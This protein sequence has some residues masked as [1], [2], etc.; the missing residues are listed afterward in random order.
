MRIGQYTQRGYIKMGIRNL[1]EKVRDD[2][3]EPTKESKTFNLIEPTEAMV[4]NVLQKYSDGET[5]DNIK[6]SIKKKG[7]NNTLSF[8]QIKEIINAYKNPLVE[9]EDLIKEDL[10]EEEEDLI[11]EDLIEEEEDLI[12][13]D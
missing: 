7:S 8:S 4:R 1:V 12:K 6:K 3:I 10:I 11:K 9:E 5:L 2:V 13:E